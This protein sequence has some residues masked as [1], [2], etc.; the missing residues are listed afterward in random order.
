MNL[1]IVVVIQGYQLSLK[2]NEAELLPRHID[3]IIE[4]WAEYDPDATGFISP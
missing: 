2:E 3:T 4:K 1:F